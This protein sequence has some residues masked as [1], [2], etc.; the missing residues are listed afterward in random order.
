M[1]KN[2]LEELK[3]FVVIHVDTFFFLIE[4]PLAHIPIKSDWL[5]QNERF[6]FFSSLRVLERNLIG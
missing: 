5:K 2:I 3:E 1:N 4:I 6:F